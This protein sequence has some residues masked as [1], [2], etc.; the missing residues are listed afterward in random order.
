MGLFGLGARSSDPLPQSAINTGGAVHMLCLDS[1]IQL[2]VIQRAKT[3][4][5]NHS[6]SHLLS[7]TD[8][9]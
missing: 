6:T 4:A 1:Y 2:T 8:N 7:T 3:P 5:Q 9:K